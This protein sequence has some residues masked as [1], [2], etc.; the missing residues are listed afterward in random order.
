MDA[1]LNV[2]FYVPLGAAGLLCARRRWLGWIFAVAS[3]CSLS[4][5][6]EWVQLWSAQRYGTYTDLLANSAGA[7]AGATL[8]DLASRRGWFGLWHGPDPRWRIRPAAAPLLGAWMLWHTFPFIP[9]ISLPRLTGVVDL[10]TPWSWLTMAECLM[11]FAMLRLAMGRTYWLW[12]A[13][14]ALPAQG[15]LMDRSLSPAALAG[16]AIG[17]VV[18]ARGLWARVRPELLLPVWLAVEELRPFRLA[19]NHAFAWIPFSAW[20]EAPPGSYYAVVFGKLFLYLAMIWS[21]RRR[22]SAWVTAVAVPVLIAAVGEW[23]QQYLEART[24][25]STEVVLALAAAALLMIFEERHS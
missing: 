13:F 6:I 16:A 24:P 8:A 20:Y 3:G 9:S 25:D 5:V 19:P 4:G 18:A 1:V 14:A 10:A 7:M 21:L 17:W 23:A 15:L 22:G 2:L 11:G 12:V